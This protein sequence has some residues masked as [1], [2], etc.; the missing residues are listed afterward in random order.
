MKLFIYINFIALLF[1]VSL[2]TQ[3]NANN[4]FD[5]ILSTYV[6]SSGN[7]NYKGIVDN[8]FNI[9]HPNYSQDSILLPIK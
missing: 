1:S 6:D 7:V 3:N 5:E 2:D 9:F 4:S 8:P